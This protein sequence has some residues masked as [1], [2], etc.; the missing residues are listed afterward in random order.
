MT[1]RWSVKYFPKCLIRT[2]KSHH[3]I[4]LLY[5]LEASLYV[6]AKI[7]FPSTIRYIEGANSPKN[8]VILIDRSGS[9][10]GSRMEIASYAARILVE[11]LTTNDFFHVVTVTRNSFI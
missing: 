4:V 1:T 2:K 8:V 11:T 5:K 6:F 3:V 10:L 9:L 7:Y